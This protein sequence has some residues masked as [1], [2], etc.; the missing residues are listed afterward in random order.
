MT[1]KTKLKEWTLLVEE[2]K[3]GMSRLKITKSRGSAKPGP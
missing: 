2:L 3:W 1:K